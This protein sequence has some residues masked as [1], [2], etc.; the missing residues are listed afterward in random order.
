MASAA[1]LTWSNSTAQLLRGNPLLIPLSDDGAVHQVRVVM[2]NA[3]LLGELPP[4][5]PDGLGA[6][7]PESAK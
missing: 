4:G 7:L 2:A 6:A 3:P 1:A 5:S